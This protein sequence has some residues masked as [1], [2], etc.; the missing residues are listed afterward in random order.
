MK[1][2]SYLS[3]YLS[4]SVSSEFPPNF[5][6]FNFSRDCVFVS[7]SILVLDKTVNVLS[8]LMGVFCLLYGNFKCSSKIFTFSLSTNV[9]SNVFGVLKGLKKMFF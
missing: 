5:K 9:Y 1:F 3:K 7:V 6:L 8:Y 4:K 2:V